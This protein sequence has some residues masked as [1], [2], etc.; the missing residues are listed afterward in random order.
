MTRGAAHV[1]EERV[2]TQVVRVA[3]IQQ[4]HQGASVDDQRHASG[5]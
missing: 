4:G 3:G 2:T 1:L 5:S